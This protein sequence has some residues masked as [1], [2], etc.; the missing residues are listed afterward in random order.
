[1]NCVKLKELSVQDRNKFIK[2]NHYSRIDIVLG[3]DVIPQVLLPGLKTNVG[4]SL[5]AQNSIFGWILSGPVTEHVSS[6]TT[7]VIEN[8]TDTLND[9]LKKFWEQEE[10]PSTPTL[11][12][13]DVFCEN[14]YERSTVR[15]DDGRY[16]VKLPFKTIFPDT[17]ALGHSRPAAQQQ[18]LSIERSIERKP[19][20]QRT[21]TKFL[22][23]YLTLDH[24][25]PTA[26][27]EIIRDG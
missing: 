25:E 9:L 8:S 14:P 20:L 6:F 15:R 21:Y 27:Q 18:Y 11:T 16:V 24:M 5:I 19:E 4:G 1:M 26:S 13:D 3:S 17:I 10:V 22:E 2:D 23:E 12:D 7:Q